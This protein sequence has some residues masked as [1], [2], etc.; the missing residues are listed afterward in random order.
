MPSITMKKTA[1]LSLSV[2]ALVSGASTFAASPPTK[3]V[4]ILAYDTMKYSVTK[5]EASP[6]QKLVVE[7]KSEGVAPKEV[8]SHNWVLLNS[9]EDPNSYSMAAIAA[10]AEDYQPKA[11]AKKVL[12]SIHSLGPKESAKT[13]F[14]APTKPGTYPYLCTF[15]AHC[16]G[17]MRGVLV[18]K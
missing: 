13:T 9:G 10:K 6:G 2:T 17:G 7:L 4:T 16:M 18:V 11:L 1:L 14:T 12:A 15:P 3:T 5:I 8:M